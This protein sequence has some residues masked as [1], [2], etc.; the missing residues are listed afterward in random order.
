MQSN[1]SSLS[2]IIY[3]FQIML[4]LVNLMFPSELCQ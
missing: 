2:I 4:L 3:N 1:A